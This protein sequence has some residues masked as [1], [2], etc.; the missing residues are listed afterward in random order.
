MYPF[1]LR[2]LSST[3]TNAGLN[4]SSSQTK[5]VN[6]NVIENNALDASVWLGGSILASTD[7]FFDTC[8]TKAQYEEEGSRVF[9][10]NIA[11]KASF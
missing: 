11:F 6:V 9:R 10:N 4:H 1:T 3:R 2:R 8:C 7:E 5:D